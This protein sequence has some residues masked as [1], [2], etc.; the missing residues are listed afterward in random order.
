MNLK[1]RIAFERKIVRMVAK[2]A[3][4]AGYSVSLSD[5]DEW[6]V[7]ISRDLKRIVAAAMT[8]DSDILRL[9]NSDGYY[10]GRIWFV[11]GNAGYDVISDHTAN[12]AIE[13]LLAPVSAYIET[14]ELA[15]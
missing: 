9:S 5:G 7:K 1:Q 13:S 8:T 12:D 10:V 14:A 4:D 11:Y 15:A 2:L 3:I 6:V